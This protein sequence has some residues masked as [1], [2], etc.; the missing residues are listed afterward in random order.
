MSH[1]LC[2][3][4]KGL[5]LVVKSRVKSL[6]IPYVAKILT[7][8]LKTTDHPLLNPRSRRLMI[9]QIIETRHKWALWDPGR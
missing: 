5:S 8:D 9:S 3:F 6:T 1:S 7:R 2:G 4:D